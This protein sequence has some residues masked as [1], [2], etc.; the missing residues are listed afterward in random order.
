MSYIGKKGVSRLDP[1]NLYNLTK[2]QEMS[3]EGNDPTVVKIQ[4]G[5]ELGIDGLWRYEIPDPFMESAAIEDY[6]KPRFGEPVNI[7]MILK[8]SEI[9]DAYPELKEVKIYAMY[10]PQKGTAG[11]YNPST[12]G[13]VISLGSPTDDFDRQIEGVLLHEVQHLIQEMEGFARGGSTKV[14]GRSRYLRLAG[15]VEARNICLRHHLTIED[16]CRSLRTDTQDVPD[17][18]QIIRFK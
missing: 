15:E 2:A 11:Y 8:D 10:S 9:L 12:N 5:W 1:D 7:R 13:M 16:R 14:I 6:V 18:N 4:T 3:I 17:N